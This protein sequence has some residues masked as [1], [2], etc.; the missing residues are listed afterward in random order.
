MF[1]ADKTYAVIIEEATMEESS[2]G[3]PGIRLRCVKPDQNGEPET[4]FATIWITDGT[5]VRVAKTLGEIG[6][7]KATMS[8]AAFWGDP[9]IALEGKRCSI[10]TEA[11]EYNGRVTVRVKYV[12]GPDGGQRPA[13]PITQETVK[14]LAN[15][16]SLIEDEVPF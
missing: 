12:N 4:I 13:K 5:K 11:N 15:A 16:F 9:N 3:T 2:K 10:V 14:S 8:S 7:D 1:E 6:V